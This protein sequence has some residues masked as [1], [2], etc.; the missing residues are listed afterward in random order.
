MEKDNSGRAVLTKHGVQQDDWRVYALIVAF[1]LSLTALVVPY[2]SVHLPLVILIVIAVIFVFA[3]MKFS[4]EDYSRLMLL[5]CVFAPFQKILPGDFNGIIRGFNVTNIFFFFLVLGWAIQTLR[6]EKNFYRRRTID[7]PLI[8]FCLLGLVSLFRREL[9]GGEQTMID[10]IFVMKEWLLP[11]LIYFVVVNNI[12]DRRTLVRL[13]VVICITTS[14]VAFLGMK[15]FYMDKGGW[16][17]SFSSYDKARIGVISGQPNQ[18]GA[19]FSYYTFILAAFFLLRWRKFRYW[20]LLIPL[21][22]CW[23][24]TWLTFSRGSQVA[25]SLAALATVFLWSRKVF[26]FFVVPLIVLLVVFPQLVPDILVGRMANTVHLDGSL[27]HSSQSRLSVWKHAIIMIKANP[28]V[29]VGYGNFQLHLH[30]YGLPSSTRGIDAHNTYLLY[31]AE[32]GIP[33]A[34]LFILILILCF[35]KGLYVFI[36]SRDNFFRATAM[37]FLAGLIGLIVSNMFGS[38]LNSNEIVFQFWILVAVIMHMAART[39]KDKRERDEL[40]IMEH[41]RKVAEMAEHRPFT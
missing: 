24:T 6:L 4:I 33:A 2:R 29:G 12:E 34:L 5:F 41:K 20:A 31:A 27:D 36:W 35:W 9:Y 30:E 25:F 16:G 22:A 38:R 37:G 11:M 7:I 1:A 8:M 23:R 17:G 14:L 21:I 13:V 32:M 15:K 28:I 18:L 10:S 39:R 19:F 3:C 40:A 26:V